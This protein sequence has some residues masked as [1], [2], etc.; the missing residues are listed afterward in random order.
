MSRNPLL[1]NP[2]QPPS[3]VFKAVVHVGQITQLSAGCP[4]PATLDQPIG[5]FHWR[6]SRTQRGHIKSVNQHTLTGCPVYPQ[7]RGRC[8]P[9]G[10]DWDAHNFTLA[11]GAS[12]A[13]PAAWVTV[14]CEGL[15]RH[16]VV[17]RHR[18]WPKTGRFVPNQTCR[19]LEESSAVD[20]L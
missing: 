18:L 14:D 10:C 11:V 7:R 4:G 19:Y 15:V 9:R 2:N 1:T 17:R 5:W 3:N 12:L 8:R 13:T 20:F 16:Q 6:L